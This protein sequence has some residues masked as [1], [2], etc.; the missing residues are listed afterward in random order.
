VVSE[1]AFDTTGNVVLDALVPGT[2]LQID[3][4]S[5]D[6]SMW[7]VMPDCAAGWMRVAQG[8]GDASP[9]ARVHHL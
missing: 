4:E 1:V 8:A 3:F 9:S 6:G 7:I 2:A 5:E